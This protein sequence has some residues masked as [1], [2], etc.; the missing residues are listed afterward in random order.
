VCHRLSELVAH[1]CYQ[2]CIAMTMIKGLMGSLVLATIF[3]VYFDQ[4]ARERISGRAFPQLIALAVVFLVSNLV[5]W[6]VFREPASRTF[7]RKL[8]FSMQLWLFFFAW[9][10]LNG[11]WLHRGLAKDVEPT[12]LATSLFL[13]KNFLQFGVILALLNCV[14]ARWSEPSI[15]PLPETLAEP[16]D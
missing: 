1:N 9:I 7:R 6:L 14:V 11:V 8:N 2:E 3:Q 5:H 12:L 4:M 16:A 13:L 15:S 10:A